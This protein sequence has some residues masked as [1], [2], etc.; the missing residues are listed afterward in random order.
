MFTWSYESESC[1]RL[2]LGMSK[3]GVSGP[4]RAPL[5]AGGPPG[6]LLELKACTF[7]GASLCPFCKQHKLLAPCAELHAAPI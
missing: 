6:M 5:N 1:G 3:S 2:P 4:P 7:T